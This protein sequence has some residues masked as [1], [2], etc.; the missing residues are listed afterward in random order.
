MPSLLYSGRTYR[1]KRILKS[2]LCRSEN[3]LMLLTK[4]TMISYFCVFNW[5]THKM[6]RTILQIQGFESQEFLQHSILRLSHC[7]CERCDWF[8]RY[9]THLSQVSG[10]P[11]I[12]LYVHQFNLVL[13]A[14]FFTI[15]SVWCVSNFAKRD[16]KITS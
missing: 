14:S 3:T 7:L 6:H 13:G 1:R 2:L 10:R 16:V 5:S 12:F 8:V 15:I 4:H 11:F 9:Y